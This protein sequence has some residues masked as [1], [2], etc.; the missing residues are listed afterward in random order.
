[1]VGRANEGDWSF[2]RSTTRTSSRSRASRVPERCGCRK[3]PVLRWSGTDTH[4]NKSFFGCSN[5]NV[6]VVEDDNGKL[7]SATAYNNE[8]VSVSFA[9][10][11]GNLEAELR[12]HKIYNTNVR[13]AAFFSLLV[14]VLVVNCDGKNA[15]IVFESICL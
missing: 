13:I 5:Y 9:L 12:T 8:E 6:S 15:T 2:I 11:I 4:P 14:V 1:M 7:K 3:R 10:R